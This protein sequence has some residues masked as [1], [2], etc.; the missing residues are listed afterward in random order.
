MS[1]GRLGRWL[2]VVL[3]LTLFVR[4][5]AAQTAVPAAPD[6]AAQPAPPPSAPTDEEAKHKQEAKDR[7][8]RGIQLAKDSNWD[9]ALAEFNASIEALP[10]RNAMANAAICLRQLK[11]YSEAYAMYTDLLQRFG[12]AISPD[13]KAA[14]DSALSE[15]RGYIGEIDVDSKPSGA[16]VAIDGQ[17]H[18]TTP[19]P[20]TVVVNAGTHSVRVSKDG[21]NTF[22]SQVLVA[23][24]QRRAVSS[25]LKPLSRSGTLLVQDQDGRALSVLID[26]AAVGKT[27]WQGVLGLGQHS[28]ALRGEGDLGTAPSSA[29]VRAPRGVARRGTAYRTTTVERQRLSRRRRDRQWRLA[30]SSQEQRAHH[31][32]RGRRSRA[33]PQGHGDGSRPATGTARIPRA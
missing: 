9:A 17:P 2:P 31:R 29:T 16:T 1:F 7:F 13:E 5:L 4:S 30:R 32:G 18:G 19:L 11:R 28:V 24:K 12:T 14:A 15:L 26:G 23:G 10:N 8:L 33:V 21:F 3:L 27:P 25:T 22:E 6:V 20:S